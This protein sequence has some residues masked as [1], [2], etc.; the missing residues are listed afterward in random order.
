MTGYDYDLFVIGA[1]SG[2]VRAARVAAGH[3]ARVAI[4]EEWRIGGT[5]VLRGCVP[6]KL[7][8]YASRF[9]DAFED[10]LGYGWSIEGATFSWPDLVAAKNREIQRLS[11]IYE[12]NLL[13][14]TVTIHK[15][16][17]VVEGPHQIALANGKRCTAETVLVAT[18]AW[19]FRLNIPGA[20]LAITSNELFDLPQ[21][22]ETML[23]VGAGNVP[24]V[25]RGPKILRGFDEDLR[26]SATD[27]L[28]GA[29]V[30]LLLETELFEL[31]RGKDDSVV[32]T[33]HDHGLANFGA[34]MFASGR[35]PN[36]QGLGLE[37]QGVLFDP[38]GALRVDSFSQT[39]APWIYAVGDVTNR[40]NLT[41][42]AIREGHAVADTLYGG[43]PST[44]DH[45]NVPTAVFLTPEIGTVGLTEAEARAR[46]PEIDIYKTLFRPMKA[47]LSGRQER[48]LMKMVVEAKSDR[49]L[50]VHIFGEDAGEMIQLAGVAVKLG[51]TKEDFDAT[52][53]VHPTAAEELVTMRTP[54]VPPP[55]VVPAPLLEPPAVLAEEA[56]IE[57]VPVEVGTIMELEAEAEE[58]EIASEGDVDEAQPEGPPIVAEAAEAGGEPEEVPA[59]QVPSLED[60]VA[61]I[62]HEIAETASDEPPP[63][64]EKLPPLG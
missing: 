11:E 52:V 42:V 47:T 55:A 24:L 10:A 25:H 13:A 1:G 57:T 53:A 34:V 48:T 32:V 12:R 15:S 21:L 58:A 45:R 36:A 31:R 54:W 6:K 56:T 28:R 59:E 62:E 7:L 27:A 2:G 22:P 64:E 5:C 60:I 18:G 16:R 37:A 26:D 50:G 20:Q 3:G 19:P 9:A 39:T 63:A 14:S 46:H 33:F 30:K 4:A 61:E 35:I 8:V 41:P 17:A 40:L 44:T 43:R 29:G 49:V 23:I 38:I 51:A